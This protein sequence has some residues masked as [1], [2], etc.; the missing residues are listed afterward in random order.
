MRVCFAGCME[1]M[2]RRRNR[3]SIKADASHSFGLERSRL[4]LIKL[5]VKGMIGENAINTLVINN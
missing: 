1:I 5:R 4:R 2:N 3:Q